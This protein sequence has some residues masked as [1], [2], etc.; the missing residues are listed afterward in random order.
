MNQIE[1]L[2]TLPELMRFG[3]GMSGPLAIS[4]VNRP[5]KA[6]RIAYNRY[7]LFYDFI[8]GQFE[9]RYALNGLLML[10]VQPGESVLEIGFG[11]GHA[12]LKLAKTVG[13]GGHVSGI[14]ISDRMCAITRLRIHHA[15]LLDR[16]TLHRGDAQKLPFETAAFD[17][18]FISFT[19]ELFDTED[20]P[21]VLREC[22][23]VLKPRGRICIVSLLKSR[24]CSRIE[25]LY[26]WIHE[27]FPQWV[28]CRPIQARHELIQTG[29]EPQQEQ[30]QSMFGLLVSTIFAIKL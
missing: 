28:D 15:K 22:Y 9:R 21:Q 3:K 25:R 12:L 29:F 13:E 17:A 18:L 16:V 19:L 5:R 7:G 26:E 2:F 20:I 6:A 30:A 1:G 23:R 4:P 10:N 27:K 24:R 14:D 11:T 8:G